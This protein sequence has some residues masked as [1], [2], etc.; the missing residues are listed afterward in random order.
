VSSF[1]FAKAPICKGFHA[2]FNDNGLYGDFELI[3]VEPFSF[4]SPIPFNERSVGRA[5]Y[6]LGCASFNYFSRP[7]KQGRKVRTP[8]QCA[9]SHAAK[10]LARL[11][12]ALKIRAALPRGGINHP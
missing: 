4:S 6:M 2:L 1:F 12:F 9:I 3:I 10:K 7:Q 8:L 11:I 5:D